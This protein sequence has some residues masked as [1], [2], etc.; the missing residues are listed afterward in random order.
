GGGYFKIINRAVPRALETLGYNPEQIEKIER[1]AVGHGTLKGAPHINHDSLRAKGFDQEALDKLE[2][3]V[4]S[5]FDI[6]FAFNHHTLGRDFCIGKLKIAAAKLDDPKF[7]MLEALGFS[8]HDAEHAN[9][10][11][12][13][14]MTLEGAP[15]LKDEHLPVFDCANPCGKIGKRCLSW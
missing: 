3:A 8:R 4:A 2:A 9:T 5:A 14:A 10:Y 6:T 7:D 11:V 13:G 1:Y 15:G 12:A